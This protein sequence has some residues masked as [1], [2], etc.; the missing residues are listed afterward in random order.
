MLWQT[1]AIMILGPGK[2][3][4][5]EALNVQSDWLCCELSVFSLSRGRH[6]SATD[7]IIRHPKDP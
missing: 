1:R 4:Y 3:K 5:Y 2:K 7:Y 6:L